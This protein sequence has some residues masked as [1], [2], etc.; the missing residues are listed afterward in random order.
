VE[1]VCSDAIV[2]AGSLLDGWRCVVEG[3]LGALG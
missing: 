3:V 1:K 2:I